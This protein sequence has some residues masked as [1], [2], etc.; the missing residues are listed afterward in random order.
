MSDDSQIDFRPRSRTLVIGGIPWLARITDK[1]RAR[2][3]G[4]IG[5][6][7]YPCSADKKF[8]EE[9]GIDEPLFTKIV[10]ES[11]TDDEVIEKVKPFYE[12]KS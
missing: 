4:N 6:Y 3:E 5:D 1:A 7:V 8:L 11:Q 12:K 9:L 2:I 10:S